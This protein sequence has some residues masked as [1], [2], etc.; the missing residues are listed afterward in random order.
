MIDQ[1]TGEIDIPLK[2]VAVSVL[3]LAA[4]ACGIGRDAPAFLPDKLSPVPTSPVETQ[5]SHHFSTPTLAPTRILSTG[6]PGNRPSM[7]PVLASTSIPQ[8]APTSIVLPKTR[9]SRT[10]TPTKSIESRNVSRN[11]TATTVPSGA[12]AKPESSPE[13]ILEIL[14]ETNASYRI[15]E[16]LTWF[17]DPITAIARTSD[18]T[19]KI[20]FNGDGT[21]AEGSS[22]VVGV[23]TLKSDKPK[24]DGWVQRSSGLGNKVTFSVK[25][26]PGMP[27]PIPESGSIDFVLSGDMVI[28]GETIPSEWNVSA[29]FYPDAVSGTASTTV[30]WNEIGLSK[31]G[32]SFIISV[33]DTILL[34]IDFVASR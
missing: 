8:P 20:I 21:I 3:V 10:P 11:P 23:S 13:M 4:T 25:E 33:D 9:T 30:T 22:I 34:E 28:A 6:K 7:K 31:P 18:V 15:G 2:Y 26:N 12:N 32:L 27:W 24:R 29:T 5:V 17:P 16:T 1:A 19:G 14:D